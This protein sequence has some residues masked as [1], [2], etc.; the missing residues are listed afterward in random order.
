[1]INK[2]L[3]GLRIRLIDL[4]LPGSAFFLFFPLSPFRCVVPYL[5]KFLKGH[6]KALQ[7]EK[8]K[9]LGASEMKLVWLDLL[10][11]HRDAIYIHVM[12]TVAKSNPDICHDLQQKSWLAMWQ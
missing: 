12:A 5:Y 7:R 2:L 11:G 1:M 6:R 10:N 8:W 4:H 9:C 3:P